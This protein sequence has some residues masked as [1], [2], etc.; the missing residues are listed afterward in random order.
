MDAVSQAGCC[1]YTR[2]TS[3]CCGDSELND[4]HYLPRGLG[5]FRNYRPLKDMICE[6]CNGRFSKLDEVLLNSGPEALL[7]R[8]HGIKGRSAHRAKDLFHE[9]NQ[10]LPPLEVNAWLPNDPSLTRVE[11]V[12]RN[13]AQPRRELVFEDEDGKQ[14]IVPVPHRVNSVE[15]LNE[16]LDRYGVLGQTWP[17]VWVNCS[18][19]DTAFV[20]LVEERYGK[21]ETGGRE[22]DWKGY[23]ATVQATTLVNLPPEYHRA[24]A[25]IGFHFFLWCFG[26]PLTG[27]EPCFDEVKEFIFKGGDPRKFITC[28]IGGIDRTGTQITTW[29]H[30]LAAGWAGREMLAT[31][32]LF[33]GSNLGMSFVAGSQED[34][35]FRGNMKDQALIWF[36]QLGQMG[37]SYPWRRAAAFVGYEEQRDGF[38]GEVQE[39]KPTQSAN[40]SFW[41]G[42]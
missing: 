10:G 38:D 33:A 41:N 16:H 23:P 18:A 2:P 27:F 17:R 4:E 13:V 30:V 12:D 5:N 19:D 39:L 22:P 28:T 1:I 7:R 26:P 31:V 20:S 37:L 9:R 36:V 8:G 14:R 34:K 25:K 3:L 11:V 15:A 21:I 29:A 40:G 35:S 42:G 24:I 32:Q 6:R